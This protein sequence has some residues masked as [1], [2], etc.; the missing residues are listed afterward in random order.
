LFPF[1]ED[2]AQT[3]QRQ[4]HRYLVA[5]CLRGC[6][7]T[8]SR[9]AHT[10]GEGIGAGERRTIAAAMPGAARTIGFED[11]GA[12]W[13]TLPNGG[14][15]AQF[16]GGGGGG[17]GD[18]SEYSQ[19]V[20]E[21][22]TGPRV[23]RR[24]PVPANEAERADAAAEVE[25]LGGDGEIP[26]LATLRDSATALLGDP[27]VCFI[28]LM[29][30]DNL[31]V[32]TGNV[33]EEFPVRAVTSIRLAAPPRDCTMC[34]HTLGEEKHLVI[35]DITQFVL[36]DATDAF[37]EAF[38]AAVSECGGFPVPAVCPKTGAHKV[39]G[40]NFYAGATIRNAAGL[41]IGTFC[42]T[43]V[44][45]RPDFGAREAKVLE[46]LAA[47]AA[48]VIER[49][50]LVAP[51]TLRML[52][53][54][55]A[56]PPG[57][58]CAF[59][60]AP[61]A[62]TAAVDAVVLG[63]GPAGA[64]AACQL[65]FRGL[66][67]V[68][69]E[70]KTLFGAPT[71]VSSKIMREVGIMKGAESTWADVG[72][73]GGLIAT[74]DAARISAMVERYGVRVERGSG[75]VV[76]GT[77]EDAP[78]AAP[79]MRIEV[80]QPPVCASESAPPAVLIDARSLVVATGSRARRVGGLPPFDGKHVFDSDTINGVGRKPKSVLIQGAGIIGMEY[81]SIFRKMGIP[82]VVAVSAARAALLPMLD[83]SITEALVGD[84]ARLGVQLMFSTAISSLE[85]FEGASACDAAQ[86]LGGVELADGGVRA[87]LTDK[88][89]GE[90][91]VVLVDVLLSCVG[92]VPVLGD[93][94][95][96]HVCS[97]DDIA[98]GKCPPADN[99]TH[100][101]NGVPH[102][103]YVVGDASGTSGLACMGAL[104]A[105]HAVEDLLPRLLDRTAGAAPPKPMQLCAPPV[106]AVAASVVWTI[107]EIA[108]VGETEAAATARLGAEN[109]VVAQASFADTTR[110]SIEHS[111][112]TSFV[113][114]VCRR[115]DGV[116]LGAHLHGDGCAECVHYGASLVRGGTS[117]FDAQYVTF[118]AVTLHE[119]WRGAA[120]AV[121][122]AL[123][124]K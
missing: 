101:L 102:N 121:I 94:G 67:V 83:A 36:R 29:T 57:V 100:R 69:V 4:C 37:P 33:T 61:K 75:R 115:R 82:V 98:A 96:E 24:A 27:T 13:K 48:L 51:A 2:T 54:R 66:S 88:N 26:E 110:G 11:V 124:P 65:S 34:A 45:P 40:A 109:V 44:R 60:A 16:G 74:Q 7:V 3:M 122:E 87:V 104:Q 20:P 23:V 6:S 32:L 116:V 56:C 64:T 42:I 53:R 35:P 21:G 85:R 71:G 17:G 68:L 62:S 22:V 97:G 1:N 19:S 117:V 46:C 18:V 84:A 58:A 73:V 93:M 105:Q 8:C 50:A 113:K 86:P 108:F 91:T 41:A 123:C 28:A 72:R 81:A 9:A 95:L 77:A 5:H 14:G 63:G 25:Q 103:V 12:F 89:T 80:S 59:A 119:V 31:K 38:R 99:T 79:V 114:L 49:H 92:R 118:P 112:A 78:D 30:A 43:D 47:Q 120:R 55:R 70:P 107:P 15:E 52:E 76:C 111:P 106:V 39:I 10:S 90:T